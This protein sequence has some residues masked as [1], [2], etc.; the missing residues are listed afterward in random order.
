LSFILPFLIQK[1]QHPLAQHTPSSHI[2]SKVMKYHLLIILIPGVFLLLCSVNPDRSGG[3][4]NCPNRIRN[5]AEFKRNRPNSLSH[6]LSLSLS[7][8]ISL[9]L[10]LSLSL[11]LSFSLS[12]SLFSPIRFLLILI[13]NSLIPRAQK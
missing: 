1:K 2:Q 12:L 4:L 8:T 5:R 13:A 10:S 3:H 11:P 9:S 6:T 7:H